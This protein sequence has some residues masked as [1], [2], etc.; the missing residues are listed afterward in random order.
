MSWRETSSS[1]DR[2]RVGSAVMFLVAPSLLLGGKGG[3]I[4]E[5]VGQGGGSTP[6]PPLADFLRMLPR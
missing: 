5:R 6:G 4:A 2:V 3:S 1:G